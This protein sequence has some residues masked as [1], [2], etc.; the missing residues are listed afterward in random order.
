[1]RFRIM[2]RP[3]SLGSAQHRSKLVGFMA[4]FGLFGLMAPACC[5]L[6]LWRSGQVLPLFTYGFFSALSFFLYAYDKYRATTRGWRVREVLLHTL[7][8][9]GGWPGGMLAQSLFY[10]KT[11]KS[12]FQLVFWATVVVH[13]AFW[14]RWLLS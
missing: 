4:S 14:L 13:E 6:A 3:P 2:N 9:L 1:M 12:S 11:R 5:T 8:S 10:H 7:D